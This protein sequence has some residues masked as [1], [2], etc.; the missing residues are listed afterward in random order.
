V[1]NIHCYANVE[2]YVCN[3]PCRLTL[4]NQLLNSMPDVHVW[5]HCQRHCPLSHMCL[6]SSHYWFQ[7][8]PGPALHPRGLG[9]REPFT[10]TTAVHIRATALYI[11]MNLV[12][13]TCSVGLHRFN[14]A[15]VLR[16]QISCLSTM[17]VMNSPS[18]KLVQSR[19]D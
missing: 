17:L 5:L 12:E 7:L 9:T 10:N 11:R 16:H 4:Q 6:G 13:N 8:Q 3:L 15:I 19:R 14:L 18:H 1:F 2:L